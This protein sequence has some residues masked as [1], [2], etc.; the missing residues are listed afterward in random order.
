MTS[1]ALIPADRPEPAIKAN[2][3]PGTLFT[4]GR[5]ARSGRAPFPATRRATPLVVGARVRRSP[6]RKGQNLAVALRENAN[7]APAI[8]RTSDGSSPRH[9][10]LICAGRV[11]LPRPQL[12]DGPVSH[13]GSSARSV[14]R[15]G[16]AGHYHVLGSRPGNASQATNLNPS[17]ASPRLDGIGARLSGMLL[18]LLAA[19][20][21]LLLQET[22]SQPVHVRQDPPCCM[23]DVFQSFRLRFIC[24]ETWQR[25]CALSD[26]PF[27]RV[28]K[29][30]VEYV[31]ESKRMAD[32][33]LHKVHRGPGDTVDAAL[34]GASRLYGVPASWLHRLRYRE[35]RDLPT[36]AFFAIVNAYHAAAEAGERAYLAE[37]EL[38]DARN[39][40]VAGLA[41][42]LA[43]PETERPVSAKE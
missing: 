15:V 7:R 37:R 23:S 40:K 12:S 33:I 24:P 34:P 16:S 2:A 29:M 41:R 38:A 13:A 32:F 17:G 1:A 30:A 26:K 27:V 20:R 39:S 25:R 10:P 6:L 9:Y 4:T 28:N 14:H 11:A 19:P 42:T 31:S 8:L 35:I 3:A 18:P 36:S 21:H 43:G 22:F 5:S